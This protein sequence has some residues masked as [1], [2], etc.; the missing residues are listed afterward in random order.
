VKRALLLL[1]LVAAALSVGAG[2]AGATN[3]C[4]GFP[5]C[6]SVPGPWVP[7]AARTGAHAAWDLKCP[8]RFIVG[9]ID[10]LVSDRAIDVGFQGMVGGPVAPGLATG[11][12]ALISGMY[13]GAARRASAF[14]PFIGCIPT[15]GGGGRETTAYHASPPKV[16]PAGRPTVRRAAVVHLRPGLEGA[17]KPTC[18][19]KERLVSVDAAAGFYTTLPPAASAAAAVRV[20]VVGQTVRISVGRN[21]PAG[22]RADVQVVALCA[23]G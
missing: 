23:G 16:Y 4:N 15:S 1:A 5:A 13:T 8:D 6:V 7:L 14:K 12:D 21:L 22:M 9:G 19:P 11:Q 17:V 18:A 20:Q 10:A 3:E 2:S